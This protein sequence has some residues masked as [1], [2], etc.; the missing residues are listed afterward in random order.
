MVKVKQ[1]EVKEDSRIEALKTALVHLN[2]MDLHEKEEE[3]SIGE[4]IDK[5]EDTR[6]VIFRGSKARQAK[7][8]WP[9]VRELIQAFIKVGNT[10]VEHRVDPAIFDL[11]DMPGVWSK[12]QDE[13]GPES[14]KMAVR[15]YQNILQLHASFWSDADTLHVAVVVPIMRTEATIFAAYKVRIPPVL[16]G[17]RLAYLQLDEEVLLVHQATGTIA[18]TGNMDEC[19]EGDA[20]RYCNMAYVLE[21]KAEPSCQGAVWRSE[22]SEAMQRCPIRM[23]GHE[24]QC[25]RSR[26]TNS[27]WCCQTQRNAH[28]PATQNLPI[29]DNWRVST[30]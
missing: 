12:L 23:V 15:R 16:A 17:N 25:G 3:K 4:V 29:Q 22:W 28:S 19:I 18:H 6:N 5:L 30:G 1:I 21:D 7:D 2:A 11:V 27:G 14:K 9:K 24:Q 26:R 20:T 10:A 13:L 8:S